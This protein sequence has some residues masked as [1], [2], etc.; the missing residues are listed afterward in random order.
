MNEI[1][2]GVCNQ[3]NYHLNSAFLHLLETPEN[4]DF[5]D[6][7]VLPKDIV[8]DIKEG[9][10]FNANEEMPVKSDSGKQSN[11]TGTLPPLSQAARAKAL[12]ES[13]KISLDPKL[14]LFNVLGSGDKTYVVRLFPAEYCSCP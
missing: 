14:R 9:I 13:G 8:K 12:L 5:I 10:I 7:C 1:S 6:G 4:V 3:D 2:R 11:D